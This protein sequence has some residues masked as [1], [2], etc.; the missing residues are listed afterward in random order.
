MIPKSYFRMSLVLV[1]FLVGCSTVRYR[2]PTDFHIPASSH[3]KI[4]LRVGLMIPPTMPLFTIYTDPMGA[5]YAN[6]EIGEAVVNGVWKMCKRNFDD[7]VVVH[8]M[9]F[10]EIDQDIDAIMVPDITDA[11]LR[12]SPFGDGPAVEFSI[13]VKFECFDPY[14]RSIWSDTFSGNG[15]GEGAEPGEIYTNSMRLG[16][17]NLF[18]KT[19]EKMR[20]KEWWLSIGDPHRPDRPDRPDEPD[21]PDRPDHPGRQDVVG[22]YSDSSPDDPSALHA[23]EFAAAEIARERPGARLK[24]ILRVQTQVVAGRN[25]KMKIELVDGSL[26]DVVV[27]RNLKD[28]MKLTQMERTG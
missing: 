4:P 27:Y 17:E 5:G 14:E 22:G 24:R 21:H 9:D 15:I 3:R 10:D 26:W 16:L 19:V 2:A 13:R 8:S 11:S 1:T 28:I 7:A 25:Y 6:F 23:A 20:K 18:E 12:S